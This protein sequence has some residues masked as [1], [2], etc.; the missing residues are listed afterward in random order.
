M[1]NYAQGALRTQNFRPPQEEGEG[2]RPCMNEEGTGGKEGEKRKGRREGL[3][4][5]R[6]KKKMAGNR[7]EGR[8]EGKKKKKKREGNKEKREGKRRRRGKGKEGKGRNEEII[9][10]QISQKTAGNRGVLQKPVYDVVCPFNSALKRQ[11]L[12]KYPLL[13]ST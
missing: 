12:N 1:C 11:N 9:E 13:Q 10:S 2:D 5:H 8:K 7:Q 6:K 4:Q 3:R